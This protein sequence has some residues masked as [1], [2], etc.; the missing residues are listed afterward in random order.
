MTKLKWKWSKAFTSWSTEVKTLC[1]SFIWTWSTPQTHTHTHIHES[2][3]YLHQYVTSHT[4]K[5]KRENNSVMHRMTWKKISD[6]NFVF[7]PE[8]I[9]FGA[10]SKCKT[11]TVVSGVGCVCAWFFIIYK[12]QKD[13]SMFPFWR[14]RDPAPQVS[15]QSSGRG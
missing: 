13:A 2:S 14:R 7:I 9:C 6:N 11:Q 4:E 1:F 12:C 8:T 10:L 15:L 5:Q 3:D